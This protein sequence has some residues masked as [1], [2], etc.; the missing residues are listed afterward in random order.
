LLF[1]WLWLGTGD[2]QGRPLGRADRACGK[3]GERGGDDQD[4]RPCSGDHSAWHV[5]FLALFRSVADRFGRAPGSR[6]RTF[7]QRRTLV[8]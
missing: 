2:H 8:V 1:G 5:A 4:G 3:Q 6:R 7:L